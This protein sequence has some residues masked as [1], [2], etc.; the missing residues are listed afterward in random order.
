MRRPDG[1]RSGWIA[2]LASLSLALPA[3]AAPPPRPVSLSWSRLPGAET[4]RDARALAQAVEQ[5]LGHPVFVAPTQAAWTIEGRIEHRSAPDAWRATIS[6][7]DEHGALLGTR[8][9][10]S[11]SPHCEALDEQLTLVVALMIDPDAALLPPPSPSPPS[12]SP[13]PAPPPTLPLPSPSPSPTLPPAPVPAPAPPL[14]PLPPPRPP[15]PSTTFGAR[16]GPTFS[17]GLLPT[18]GLGAELR[19]HL[20][21]PGWP[22]LE[23][24]AA[25]WAPREVSNGL[26]GAT[27]SLAHAFLAACPLQV[28]RWGFD[29]APCAGVQLGALRAGGFGFDLSRQ[30]EQIVFD[31]TLGADLR[32]RLVGPLFAAAYVE[33]IVPVVRDRFFYLTAGGVKNEVFRLSPVA[34]SANLSLGVELP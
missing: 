14:P 5:R 11:E 28:A 22:T 20:R 21:P 16:L 25:V 33:M 23:I 32:R 18:L 29:L 3:Q 13:S 31:A 6:I 12:P 17:L 8:E 10:T 2:L 24:G 34:G 7:E 15:T 27:F 26:F 9:L 30:Q 4:C 19:G 1:R